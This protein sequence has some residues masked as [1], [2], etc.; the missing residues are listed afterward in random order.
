[1]KNQSGGKPVIVDVDVQME[2]EEKNTILALLAKDSGE[3]INSKTVNGAGTI[4]PIGVSKLRRSPKNLV[5]G[6]S[7]K[8]HLFLKYQLHFNFFIQ[9]FD[10][11]A[12]LE[13]ENNDK[14]RTTLWPQPG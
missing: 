1:M 11:A 7:E 5:F 4:N 9:R 6:S 12:T 8:D 3:E 2:A 13:T 10:Q 14:E